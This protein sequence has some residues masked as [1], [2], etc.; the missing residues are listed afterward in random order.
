MVSGFCIQRSAAT[1]QDGR[2]KQT[3]QTKYR[4]EVGTYRLYYVW[5]QPIHALL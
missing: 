4:I 5:E 2:E 3:L 1:V